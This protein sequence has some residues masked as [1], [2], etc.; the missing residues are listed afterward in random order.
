VVTETIVAGAPPL[1]VHPDWTYSMPWLAQGTTARAADGGP[2][3]MGFFGATPVR[4]TTARWAALRA[5]TRCP[6][7]VHARQ[8]HGAQ[9]AEHGPGDDGVFIGEGRDGHTTAQ[10]GVLLTI[11]VAD[12]VPLFLVDPDRRAIA[13]LHAGWRGAAAG[14]LEAG[15]AALVRSGSEPGGLLLHL[16]PAICG[17][18]YEVGPEVFAA[19]DRPAPGRLAPIDLRAILVRRAAA[20]GLRAER[21]TVSAHCTRCEGMEARLFHSHRAGDPER[22][23]AFLGVRA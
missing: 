3:D 12:C 9:V 21:V 6:R 7:A 8:V 23:V 2:W 13:L 22:Q 1:V 5:A 16:G 20:A 18:C 14:I 10:G 19:L 15:V 11:S 17:D 4:E